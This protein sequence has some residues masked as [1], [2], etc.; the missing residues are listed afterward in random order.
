MARKARMLSRCSFTDR[1]GVPLD[2]N[3]S[4]LLASTI[5]GWGEVGY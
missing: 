1:F 2:P 3:P 5:Q 4:P